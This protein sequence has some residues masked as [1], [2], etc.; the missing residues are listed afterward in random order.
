MVEVQ[1]SSTHTSYAEKSGAKECRI[2]NVEYNTIANQWQV[3]AVDVAK[4]VRPPSAQTA[5]WEEV[6]Q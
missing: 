2:E 3:H 4:A 5:G 6:A 1:S